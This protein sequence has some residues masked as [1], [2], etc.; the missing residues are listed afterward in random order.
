VAVCVCDRTRSL[1]TRTQVLILQHPREQDQELS[2]MPLVLASLKAAKCAVGLSWR[3]LSAAWAGQADPR[4]W[5]VL[6]PL[7]A[8]RLPVRVGSQDGVVVVDRQNHLVDPRQLGGVVVLDGTWSQAKSLWWRNPWLMKLSRMC[9]FPC[10][11]S[12]YCAL[13]IEPRPQYV[14]TLESVAMALHACGEP[15]EVPMQLRRLFRTMVQRARDFLG[16]KDSR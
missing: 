12:I 3:S 7:D 11:P 8:S 2:S 9:L 1:T 4:A 13:R 5:A 6:F 16:R 14:S 10:E 15:D